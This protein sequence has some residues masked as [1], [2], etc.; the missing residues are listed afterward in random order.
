MAATNSIFAF[1]YIAQERIFKEVK[2][3]YITKA[4]QQN[5]I[6]T[7]ILTENSSDICSH[8]FIPLAASLKCF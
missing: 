1:Y 7:K 6:S 4:L 5:C 3:F 8:I 2:N